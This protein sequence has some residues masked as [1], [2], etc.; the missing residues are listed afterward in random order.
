LIA[1]GTS[2]PFDA[3]MALAQ[4]ARDFVASPSG[5]GGLTAVLAARR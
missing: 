3:G 4:E 1:G 5:R 2:L